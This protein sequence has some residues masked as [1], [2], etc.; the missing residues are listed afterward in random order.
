[1][2]P[3]PCTDVDDVAPVEAHGEVRLHGLK[4]PPYHTTMMGV[5]KGALDYYGITRTP[6]EA[7]VLSGYAFLMNVHEELC[8]S[9]PYLWRYDRFFE[10]LANLGLAMRNAGSL[11]PTADP[12]RR[13]ALEARLRGA[14]DAGV[15]CSLLNMEHQL[16]LGYDGDGFML[17]QPWGPDRSMTPARLSFGTW[18][19]FRDDL[20]V[21]FF[22][23]N[24]C[25]PR[26]ESAVSDA[27]DF[28]LDLWRH[29]E[30]Y[31]EAPYAVGAG[32]YDTWLDALDGGH[33]DGVGNWWNALVWA[34]CRARA[35]DYLQDLSEDDAPEPFADGTAGWLAP[36]YRTV[37]D[38]LTRA[39]DKS[40][41]ADD[42]RH[43]IAEAR[44]VEASCVDRIREI[45]DR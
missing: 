18:R 31:T 41:S 19:E 29:P 20:P 24:T 22:T 7:F 23:L 21:G 12:A 45:R 4:Q 5:V 6:G 30:R 33:G 27:L 8:P 15:V 36:R 13:A 32:A 26:P 25:S 43:L 28:A 1:M 44:A 39:A 17:A 16:L 2:D 9:G 42:K 35:A 14:L 3:E 40:A 38:L 37:S 34:E 10:R 11:T